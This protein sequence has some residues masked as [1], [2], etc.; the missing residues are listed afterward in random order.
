MTTTVDA[1]VDRYLADLEA[2]LEGLPADRPP[3]APG[4]G[5]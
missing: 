3:R 4:R 5:R 1:L 2:E